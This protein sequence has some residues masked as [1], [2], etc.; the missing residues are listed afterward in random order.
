MVF[1]VFGVAKLLIFFVF[2]V[3]FRV[4]IADGLERRAAGQAGDKECIPILTILITFCFVFTV[5]D[6]GQACC[7]PAYSDSVRIIRVIC[8]QFDLIRRCY[9][10]HRL[11][12]RRRKSNI[13]SLFNI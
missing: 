7:R 11:Y 1:V 4:D 13:Y 12:I 6:S 8:M 5:I 10:F 9:I 3:F 2:D